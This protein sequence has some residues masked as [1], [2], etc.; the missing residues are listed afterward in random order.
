MPSF[1]PGIESSPA[2]YEQCPVLNAPQPPLTFAGLAYRTMM[3]SRESIIKVGTWLLWSDF[4]DPARGTDTKRTWTRS[5]A[6]P[7]MTMGI[8][9]GKAAGTGGE[10]ITIPEFL[11]LAWEL[12]SLPE[13]HA[14]DAAEAELERSAIAQRLSTSRLEKVPTEHVIRVA[15]VVWNLSHA[16]S[17]LVADTDADLLALAREW[18]I[19]QRLR[20]EYG[21]DDNEEL[22]R[23]EQRL[24]LTHPRLFVR[25][26]CD[27]L[28]RSLQNRSVHDTPGMFYLPKQR[29]WEEEPPDVGLDDY[30]AV[31]RRLSVT[32]SELRSRGEELLLH[33]TPERRRELLEYV[34]RRPIVVLDDYPKEDDAAFIAGPARF[35]KAIS[36]FLSHDV[37]EQLGP[38]LGNAAGWRGQAFERYLEEAMVGTSV[39][40]LDPK[41]LKTPDFEWIGTRYRVLIEA[42]VKPLPGELIA[43][44][45]ALVSA[46]DNLMGAVE[47][48]SAYASRTAAR[49][50]EKCVLIIVV[51]DYYADEQTSFRHVS[52]L[53]GLLNDT[54]LAAVAVLS[55]GALEYLVLSSTADEAGELLEELWL[56]AGRGSLLEQP[57]TMRP[58]RATTVPQ[59]LDEAHQ[60]LFGFGFSELDTV[61]DSATQE[62]SDV[63]E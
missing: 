1:R 39:H 57:P 42:K 36:R 45:S 46:W 19:Y 43:S 55:A 26:C 15:R 59:V 7:L 47:Q 63:P 41:G 25:A 35:I 29:T 31:I 61:A 32:A 12:F 38:R 30:G 20:I 22:V 17:Q 14:A 28:A 8:M 10:V 3:F 62:I 34:R 58:Y 4:R 40:R 18:A 37:V 21:G 56:E 53:W 9:Y 6:A 60:E 50:P 16:T 51:G 2:P 5:W 24:F 48:G 27:L 44:P 54:H 49:R 33:G 13:F 11:N 52:A 23:V